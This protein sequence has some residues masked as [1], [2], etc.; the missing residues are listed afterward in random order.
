MV[1]TK[2]V[3]IG[4]IIKITTC[5]IFISLRDDIQGDEHTYLSCMMNSRILLNQK[6]PAKLIIYPLKDH[7]PDY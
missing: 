3:Y 4:A 6:Q 2:P 7:E 5:S 1:C